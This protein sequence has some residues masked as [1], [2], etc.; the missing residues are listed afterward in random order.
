MQVKFPISPYNVT[1][2]SIRPFPQEYTGTLKTNKIYFSL[3]FCELLN[4]IH[5]M[6]IH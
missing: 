2:K 3:S 6:F 1:G 4:Q 5:E